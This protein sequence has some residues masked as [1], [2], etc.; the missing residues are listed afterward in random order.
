MVW[1][2]WHHQRCGTVGCGIANQIQSVIRKWA[3]DKWNEK[4]LGQIN[5][6]ALVVK[7]AREWRHA[8]ITIEGTFAKNKIIPTH[9]VGL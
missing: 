7:L 3:K 1:P 8:R 2:H 4:V 5:N 6:Q 9:V